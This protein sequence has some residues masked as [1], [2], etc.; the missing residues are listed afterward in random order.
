[1]GV[2]AVDTHVG[3][4][5]A[6]LRSDIQYVV[7]CARTWCSEHQFV[8]GTPMPCHMLARRL[9]DLIHSCTTRG[10]KRPLAV[11]ILVGGVDEHAGASLHRVQATGAFQRYHAVAAGRGDAAATARLAAG[12]EAARGKIEAEREREASRYATGAERGGVAGDLAQGATSLGADSGAVGSSGDGERGGSDAGD[13]SAATKEAGAAATAE[14]VASGGRQ[15]RTGGG[16]SR[17]GDPSTR[18]EDDKEEDKEETREES[19]PRHHRRRRRRRRRPLSPVH[20][21]T[22]KRAVSALRAPSVGGIGG[23]GDGGGGGESYVWGGEGEKEEGEE[24][25][26]REEGRKIGGLRA[27]ELTAAIFAAPARHPARRAPPSSAS[28]PS[29]EADGGGGGW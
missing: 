25:T 3:I 4:A 12:I 21:A 17:Q 16:R 19:N 14:E 9:A 28:P 20:R 5:A 8:F 23:G 18:S 6:G 24:E 22:L 26:R 10:G 7:G 15:E 27:S 2:W 11:D 1:G 29:R 13:G